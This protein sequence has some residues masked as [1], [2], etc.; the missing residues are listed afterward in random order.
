MN[1]MLKILALKFLSLRDYIPR[2]ELNQA[3]HVYLESENIGDYCGRHHSLID[4]LVA[5]LLPT[6]NST[7]IASATINSTITLASRNE[8][9]IAGL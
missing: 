4:R 3:R 5:E 6:T 7:P 9:F 1:R 8:V 2:V